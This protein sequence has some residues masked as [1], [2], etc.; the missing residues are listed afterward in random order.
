MV[1]G[2]II[3]LCES[4]QHHRGSDMLVGHKIRDESLT[5]WPPQFHIPFQ[6]QNTNDKVTMWFVIH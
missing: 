4:I 3:D 5:M 6:L 1:E 2:V